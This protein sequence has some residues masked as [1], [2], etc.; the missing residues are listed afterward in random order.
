MCRPAGPA[1][2]GDQTR[3][4]IGS[5]SRQDGERSDDGAKS[6]D[7]VQHCQA[8]RTVMHGITRTG[9]WP[10]CWAR[11]AELTHP[12]SAFIALRLRYRPR[13]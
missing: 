1:G 13:W 11:Y 9:T 5:A 4:L 7:H 12:E 8:D 6:G 2:A 3:R 10:M